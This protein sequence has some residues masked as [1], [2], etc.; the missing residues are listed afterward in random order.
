MLDRAKTVLITE[1]MADGV[2]PLVKAFKKK[3][4]WGIA[5]VKDGEEAIEFMLRE[6]A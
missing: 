3:P 2:R 6:Q 1:D 4:A 5:V